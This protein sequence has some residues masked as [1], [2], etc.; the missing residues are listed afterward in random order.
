MFLRCRDALRLW[1]S[2]QVLEGQ[3]VNGR[4]G[5]VAQLFFRSLAQAI[6]LHHP[7]GSWAQRH[8]PAPGSKTPGGQGHAI[9]GG[10]ASPLLSVL[11]LRYTPF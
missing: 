8:A 10:T 1:R 3:R 7:L 2:L 9:L 5:T 11:S 6:W 4:G